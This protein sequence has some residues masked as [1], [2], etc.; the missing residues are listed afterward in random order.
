MHMRPLGVSLPAILPFLLIGCGDKDPIDS[1]VPT[2]LDTAA[3]EI[4]ADTTS[5]SQPPADTAADQLLDTGTPTDS[6]GDGLT[7]AEELS[8]GTDPENPDSDGDGL[9]DYEE[10]HN[11]GTGPQNADSDF[12]GISDGD[13][14]NTY[15]TDPLDDDSDDDG[16]EDGEE[17]H[18]TDY[19]GLD[20]LSD[21]TDGDGVSD[22]DEIDDGT[23]PTDASSYSEAPGINEWASCQPTDAQTPV[24]VVTQPTSNTFGDSS[25]YYSY[26]RED[27]GGTECLCTL[28][29]VGSEKVTGITVRVPTAVHGGSDWATE[30][31][32]PMAVAVKLP[33][34]A[35]GEEGDSDYD[36][37]FR[38]AIYDVDNGVAT[39]KYNGTEYWYG[40]SIDSSDPDGEFETTSLSEDETTLETVQL[41]SDE[42]EVRVSFINPD[43]DSIGDCTRLGGDDSVSGY[44]GYLQLRL[45][46]DAGS[47]KKLLLNKKKAQALQIPL[48]EAGLAEDE[49][50]CVAGETST[51]RFQLLDWKGNRKPTLL[52]IS[53]D[54]QHAYSQ[55]TKITVVDWNGST[56]LQIGGFGSKP[57]SLTTDTASVD[58]TGDDLWIGH[59]VWSMSRDGGR[60]GFGPVV[61]ITHQCPSAQTIRE[62][63]DG[64]AWPLTWSMLDGVVKDASN[65][66]SLLDQLPEGVQSS[67]PSFLLRLRPAGE[68]AD[69]SHT[70][71]LQAHGMR[72]LMTLPLHQK[73]N[74]SLA[75][76]FRNAT[77]HLVGTVEKKDTSLIVS[78]SD[79]STLNTPLGPIS[80]E[81]VTLTLP[82]YGDDT[83]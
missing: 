3:P 31:L 24:D 62:E 39:D 65:G 44:A 41:T 75:L 76:D 57:L 74:G 14:V 83:Q 80:L 73:P 60:D 64:Q 4:P 53:G 28:S 6:D 40:F 9:T 82:G 67:W 50:A 33:W 45:D 21:D 55:M 52:A 47:E 81:A 38:L 58:I 72:S 2:S 56:N 34:K 77:W 59:G 35:N 30:L 78:L 25:Y 70:L 36:S 79:K 54:R 17:I 5:D 8:L 22:G 42:Y 19:R 51:T 46:Y 10:R 15:G 29:F 48:N 1:D 66:I 49:L 71:N 63:A 23:D 20:P 7:D 12:D 61:D 18:N 27:G 32:Y 37:G 13:E 26:D 43:G 11:Y 16:L 68:G 69:I